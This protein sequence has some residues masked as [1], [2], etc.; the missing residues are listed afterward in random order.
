MLSSLKTEF[1]K[2]YK[3][4]SGA[5]PWAN[6]SCRQS[7]FSCGLASDGINR[8]TIRRYVCADHLVFAVLLDALKSSKLTTFGATK[9]AA[10]G[11]VR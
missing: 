8:D 2:R 4:F 11:S 3:S 7:R 5:Y 6:S 1:G 10:M 9:Q